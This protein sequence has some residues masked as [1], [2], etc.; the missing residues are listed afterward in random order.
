[1]T[2]CFALPLGA[3]APQTSALLWG[4][5]A[6]QSSPLGG[7]R[8]TDPPRKSTL[9]TSQWL[10]TKIA[11]L[12]KQLKLLLWHFGPTPGT[13]K[14]VAPAPP[15]V[16]ERPWEINGFRGRDGGAGWPPQGRPKPNLEAR[17]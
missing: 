7:C 6:H 1:M 2:A 5:P 12:S 17:N 11:D 8:R 13:P 4:A 15:D 10:A 16:G 9:K 14:P 3:A